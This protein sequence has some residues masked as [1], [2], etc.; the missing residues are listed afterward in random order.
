MSQAG[1]VD[2]EKSHPQIPT[3]FITDNGI[4]I[5]IFNDLEIL[6]DQTQG[7]HTFASGNTVTISAFDATDT[8]KGVS[9]FNATHFTVTD[10]N[11]EANDFTI[12]AGSG[13]T[14]GGTLNLGGSTT[15]DLD[16]PVTVE[17]GG[18]GNTTFDAYSVICAGITNTDPFQNVSGLGNFGQVLTSNGPGTLPTWENNPINAILQIDGDSGSASGD[19]VTITGGT[20]GLT[21]SGAGSTLTIGGIL[22]VENGGTGLS[23]ASQGDILYSSAA[24]TYSLLNKDTNATRYLSNTG[25]DNNPAWA[26]VD[27]SNGVTG[28]LPVTNLDGGTSASSTTFWRGDGTWATPAGTGVSNVTGTADRITSTGGTTPQIDIASTYVGQT[29]ITTL[30]TVTTGE[31]NA[32]PIDLSL[33]VTGNLDVS[34]LNGGI[35]ADATTF[36][37]GDGT[38]ATPTPSISGPGSSTDRAVVT[39]NGTSGN[40]LYDNSSVIIDSSGR[41]TNTLQPAFL[42]ILTSTQSNVTGNSVLYQVICDTEIYDQGSNFDN[43]TGTF[44]A[45]ISGRY[46]ITFKADL[47]YGLTGPNVFQNEYYIQTSNREYRDILRTTVGR[48]RYTMCATADLDA[49]DTV[50]F[51]VV[52]DYSTQTVSVSGTSPNAVTY[53]SAYLIC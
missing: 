27:L 5:P 21:T 41:M 23:S 40:A 15:I 38:W 52:S 39:W 25:V 9:S 20:T 53:C 35:G 26:Q 19:T 42:A 46:L 50:T 45:P 18:T 51:S 10:G 30:G 3:A 37:R 31:W 8:Q 16:I 44:T 13:L 1:L 32:D 24:N 22:N 14:G 33:Y 29:S 48:T 2:I 47:D 11:V 28:N 34:H 43:T 17:N 49:A 4:A 36:W 6:G 7:I 12:T